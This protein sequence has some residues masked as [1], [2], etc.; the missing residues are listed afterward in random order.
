MTD[1]G[2][3]LA[4]FDAAVAARLDG[5]AQELLEYVAISSEGASSRRVPSA[6]A[7]ITSANSPYG[8]SRQ[9]P[10]TILTPLVDPSP[11]MVPRNR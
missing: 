2:Q 4:A 5:W 9:C 11:A 6:W 10:T 1:Q 7:S 8:D 3:D